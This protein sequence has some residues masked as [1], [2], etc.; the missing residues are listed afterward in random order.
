MT[1]TGTTDTQGLD[2]LRALRLQQVAERDDAEAAVARLDRELMAHLVHQ[3]A[4][5]AEADAQIARL[6]DELAAHFGQ[7]GAERAAAA[8]RGADAALSIYRLD[9]RIRT[10]EAAA[11]ATGRLEEVGMFAPAP[12]HDGK[13][14]NSPHPTGGTSCKRLAGH[15]GDHAAYTFR[16]SQPETWAAEIDDA[17]D[18]DD[19]DDEDDR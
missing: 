19:E 5:R 14:C 1:D 2:E 9:R 10:R 16:L 4:E 15:G 12:A 3:G 18:E 8:T 7:Q 11:G 13:F 6:N 17:D